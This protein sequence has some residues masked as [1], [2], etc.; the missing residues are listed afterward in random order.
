VRANS[1]GESFAYYPYGEERTSQADGR[2]K[3]ATYFRDTIGQDYA[4]QRYYGSATGSFF[5]VD[6]GGIKTA[7]PGDPTSWN[8]Y[9]YVQGD[10]VNHTDRHGLFLGAEQCIDD[11]NAC[12]AEDDC[13][14][15]GLSGGLN[16]LGQP[17]P[18]CPVEDPE[19]QPAPQPNCLDGLNPRDVNYVSLNMNAAADISTDIGGALS[20]VFILAWAAVESGFGTSGVAVNND[21]YFGE[22]DFVNCGPKGD[23][24]VPN[25]NPNHTAHWKGAVPCSQLGGKATPAFACFDGDTIFGS[26]WAAI[27]N[28]GGWVIKTANSMPGASVAQLAQAIANGG[29]CKEGN[30]VNGGYGQQVQADYNEL[31]PVVNC[32]FPGLG[33]H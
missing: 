4:D 31:M 30:C 23:T 33:I 21:N 29:W 2:D 12:L 7:I 16:L 15:D 14:G 28:R 3:F 24:C 19:P 18:G 5:T 27:M 32:L 26:A 8:R 20:P 6:P 22:K 11:P 9:A 25:T 17:D 13:Y 10:P 1:Q